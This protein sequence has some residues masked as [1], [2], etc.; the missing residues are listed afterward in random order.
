MLRPIQLLVLLLL[1]LPAC[2]QYRLASLQDVEVPNYEPR[3]VL[4]PPSCDSLIARA[5]TVGM[6]LFTDTEASEALFCQQQQIIR[7]Q[8]EEAASKRLEAHAAA[9]RFALQTATV[10]ITGV[11]A[12]LAWIF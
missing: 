2:S 5:A 4:V 3:P 1:A 12:V 11:V 6:D 10:V 7:A 9:A 8:E